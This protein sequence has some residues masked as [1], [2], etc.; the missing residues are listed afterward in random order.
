MPGES[1]DTS[2]V[3]T[4]YFNKP[5]YEKAGYNYEST[6]GNLIIPDTQLEHEGNYTF[7]VFDFIK[8]TWSFHLF[9]VYRKCI[10]VISNESITIE[11]MR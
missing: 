9:N 2:A 7:T 5:I 3:V 6:T 4:N 8:T 11:I 10:P 1:E